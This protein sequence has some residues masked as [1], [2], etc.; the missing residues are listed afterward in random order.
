MPERFSECV[1]RRGNS[2]RIRE[3]A[4]TAAA[5]SGE[6][7]PAPRERLAL[8]TVRR[9]LRIDERRVLGRH[10]RQATRP[11]GREAFGQRRGRRLDRPAFQAIGEKHGPTNRVGADT[12]ARLRESGLH[13]RDDERHA[14]TDEVDRR[15]ERKGELPRD[16]AGA[17]GPVA[18]GRVRQPV[19]RRQS[20]RRS[21]R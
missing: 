9:R 21:T 2:S 6:E 10:K 14:A 12:E 1:V 7:R 18:L 16:P 13:E 5:R 3:H 19:E 11:K 15:I 20:I 8:L 17:L 4:A